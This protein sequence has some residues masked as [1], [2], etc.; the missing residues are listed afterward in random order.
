[1]YRIEFLTYKALR[2]TIIC[3]WWLTFDAQIYS[4]YC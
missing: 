2:L 4:L 1:M 3:L